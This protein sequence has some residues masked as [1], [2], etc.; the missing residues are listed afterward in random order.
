MD[1]LLVNPLSHIPLFC[2]QSSRQ[3][4][5]SRYRDPEEEEPSCTKLM[6]ELQQ[7]LTA[8]RPTATFA[9]DAPAD[10]FQQ[11]ALR[12][13]HSEP[14]FAAAVALSTTPAS[15]RPNFMDHPTLDADYEQELAKRRQ[16][17]EEAAVLLLSQLDSSSHLSTPDDSPLKRLLDAR[18]R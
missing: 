15:V 18:D 5:D 10:G 1:S 3:S 8:P 12:K 7:A 9:G 16:L 11:T 4:T 13:T 2:Q 14:T 6:T 17:C